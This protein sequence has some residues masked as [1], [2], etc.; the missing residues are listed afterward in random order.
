MPISK[1]P[2]KGTQDLFNNISDAG[3]EGTKV[4]AGTTA[5]R[6]ST[7]GQWRYNTD[8]NFFEG[9][10][11]AGAFSTLEPT[12]TIESVDDGEVDSAAGGNQT[13]VVTGTNFSSGGTISF[14]GTS[15]TFNAATTTF[16]SATQV[17]AVAPKASFL[18]AQEPYKVRFTSAGGVIGTSASGLIN[19]DNAPTWTTN[20]GT[21]ATI[22]DNAT[23]THATLAASD[24]EG[25]TITYSE[26]GATNLSGAGFTLNSSTGAITGDPNDV[27]AS[28]TVSFT[29]RATA[30]SK[31]ADRSFAIVVNP[32][33]V[34]DILGGLSNAGGHALNSANSKIQY[35]I[36]P[37]D[38]NSYSSGSSVTNRAY[39]LNT[40]FAASATMTLTNM[41]TGG[42]GA[43]KYFTNSSNGSTAH[44]RN[45][46][47][48]HS[49]GFS[50]DADDQIA[51]MGWWYPKV[52]LDSTGVLWIL[53][54]G[55]W[56]PNGQVG[57]RLQ[58]TN[59]RALRGSSN[60]IQEPLP[61]LSYADDWLFVCVYQSSNGGMYM[62]VG[63]KGDT[64]LT[65]VYDNGSFSY[66][67]GSSTPQAFAVGARPDNL[68]NEYNA[69][70]TRLGFQA[71]WGIGNDAFLDSTDRSR[72]RAKS[73]FESVFDATKG[74]Y[75]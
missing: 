20:A 66:S 64:N 1:I 3:T 16:N 62:G 47:S 73:L 44:I 17:T 28:T 49:A 65:D 74:R 6:G 2:G 26:T 40:A 50:N 31:T 38:S 30:G 29:G 24:A 12:P 72:T 71:M 19:V 60:N 37:A 48:G 57:I 43:G 34:W 4:A 54:D 7:T 63:Q 55:D 15:A 75:A 10:T 13:I 36:D 59:F 70:G 21:V 22:N 53:N 32:A 14:V 56:G 41:T 42:S 39:A 23:G 27:A 18:N 33:P 69:D 11:A 9:R 51:Y 67:T 25:D 68:A 46:N 45:S 58:S 8:T 61:S 5:Q 35:F 52:D